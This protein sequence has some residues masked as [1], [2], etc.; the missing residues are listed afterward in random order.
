MPTISTDHRK[1]QAWI[2]MDSYLDIESSSMHAMDSD[3]TLI[4]TD[5]LDVVQIQRRLLSVLNKMLFSETGV[6]KLTHTGRYNRTGY[7]FKEAISG[8]TL[9]GRSISEFQQLH[10]TIRLFSSV[11]KFHSIT[12]FAATDAT[13]INRILRQFRE[14]AQ[15][16]S[17]KRQIRNFQR[18][19]SKNLKGSLAY[20]DHLFEHYSRLLVVRVDLS[21]QKDIIRNKTISTAMIRAH[22]KCLFK[23]IHVHPL[24]ENCLGYLWKLEYGQRKGFHYHTCFFFDGSKVRGDIMLARRIGEFWKNEITSGQGLYFNCN[25]IASNYAQS[26]IGDIHY[27]NHEKR[28]A[29]QKAI[30]YITKVDTAVRLVLPQGARTF[31]RGECIT[32]LEKKRGRP[33]NYSD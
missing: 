4:I 6:L 5:D 7:F 29:L 9:L 8:L 27:A 2:I 28:Y 22:R 33:R 13:V 3:A 10:P 1:T 24:F 11:L 18:A 30:T 23:R 14:E 12:E 25:A 31:G 19:A 20:V 15:S 21:Y 32:H 26:G 17:H 16:T